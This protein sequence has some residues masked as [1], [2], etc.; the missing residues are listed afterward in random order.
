[1]G[2]LFPSP[3]RTMGGFG[4]VRRRRNARDPVQALPQRSTHPGR[5]RR[6]RAASTPGTPMYIPTTN[7]VTLYIRTTTNCVTL[8]I[9]TTTNHYR[10]TVQGLLLFSPHLPTR[11]LFGRSTELLL[12]DLPVVQREKT[13]GSM[14]ENSTGLR[15]ERV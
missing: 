8:Y 14:P 9:R 15:E 5:S 2:A 7:C 10:S 13:W 11:R 1:M 6:N 4:G 3:W 12:C